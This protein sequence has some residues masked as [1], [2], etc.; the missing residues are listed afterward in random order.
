MDLT[1]GASRR[2]RASARRPRFAQLLGGF[3]AAFLLWGSPP[4]TADDAG[5][6]P[7]AAE[8]WRCEVP[9]HL[10]ESPFALSRVAHR[11]S[12]AEPLKVVT[13]GSSST[14]GAGASSPSA[15]YPARLRAELARLFPGSPITVVNKG[16]G[17]ETARQMLA[18]F[19]RDVV[20]QNPDLAIWQTGTNSAL[21]RGSYQEL[22]DSLAAGIAIARRANIDILLMG[23]QKAPAFDAV[24]SHGTLVGGLAAIAETN[25]VPFFNRYEVMRHWHASGQI[26]LGAAINRDGL[27]MTDQGYY[28]IGRL[29]GRMIANLAGEKLAVRR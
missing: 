24:P 20:E 12:L 11:V 7:F 10:L 27:H 3:G 22:V 17:G 16:V 21:K 15:T 9:A 6:A 28:C 2:R 4:A 23:P 8:A 19:Q 26:A 13:I 18:R 5:S 29:L 14:S 25:G 1:P